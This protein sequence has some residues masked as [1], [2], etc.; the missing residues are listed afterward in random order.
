MALPSGEGVSLFLADLRPW[1]I[2]RGGAGHARPDGCRPAARSQAC[3]HLAQVTS[4]Q[5]RLA[6]GLGVCYH[7]TNNIPGSRNTKFERNGSVVS[8]NAPSYQ[9]GPPPPRAPTLGG[10]LVVRCHPV[11]KAGSDSH[12]WVADGG[13]KQLARHTSWSRNQA[14]PRETSAHVVRTKLPPKPPCP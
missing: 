8:P 5:G 4:S 6:C 3:P 7:R 11:G 14:P 10:F 12:T 9:L 2:A 1:W 13:G